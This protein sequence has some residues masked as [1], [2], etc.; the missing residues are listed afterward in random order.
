MRS[1]LNECWLAS[2]PNVPDGDSSQLM[3]NSSQKTPVLR[4]TEKRLIPAAQCYTGRVNLTH[5]DQNIRTLILSQEPWHSG[6]TMYCEIV[7]KDNPITV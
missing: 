3:L 5:S 1:E 6:I 2:I 7:R 4:K